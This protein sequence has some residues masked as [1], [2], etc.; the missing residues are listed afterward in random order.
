[1]ERSKG[2][3]KILALLVALMFVAL[4]TRLW[5]LQVL[6]SETYRKEA[7]NN[8]VRT[9]ETEPLRGEIFDRNG[10][11]VVS[12]RRAIE[13]RVIPQDLQESGK[14]EKVVLRL[15]DL[16]GISVEDL[17]ERM[18]NPEFYPFQP[19]PIVTYDG[20]R[21]RELGETVYAAIAER[22]R[23]YPGV[24][25]VKTT[26]R[27]YPQ[28]DLGAQLLGWLG[29]IDADELEELEKRG[30][31]PNDVVGKS[32][33]ERRW[34][35]FLRGKPGLEKFLVNA[36]GE[37]LRRLG[38]RD[39]VQ[40][41]NLYLTLDAGIQTI[42]EDALEKGIHEAR[43]H[44]DEDTGRYLNAPAGAVVV[45][46]P[47]T[48]GVIAMASW[49]SFDPEWF[50]AGPSER[51]QRYLF[52]S[53]QAPLLNRATQLSYSPGS[54]FKPFVALAAVEEGIAS[55]GGYY[56]CV[57]E[58]NAATDPDGRPFTNWTSDYLGYMTIAD[59][60]RVSCDT[61]YYQWGDRFWLEWRNEFAAA[62]NDPFQDRLSEWGFGSA[63]GIDLPGETDGLVPDAAWKEK[64]TQEH[65]E[66]FLPDE[67]AWLPGDSILLSIGG[68][69][70]LATPLQVAQAYGAIANGGKLCRPHLVERIVR[71]GV[72]VKRVGSPCKPVPY[73]EAEITYIR[74]A[75][76]LV[77]TG[78]T[79]ASVFRG[80]PL[81]EVP[82]A[83]KTGTAERAGFQ[84]TSWFAA[85]V[86][87]IDDPDYVVVAMVEE[88]G[89]GSET[90]APIVR[91]IVEGMYGITCQGSSDTTE[92]D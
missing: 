11:P 56:P 70:M 69:S 16:L 50:V 33:L 89:F 25:V 59:S 14:A 84:D 44:F 39:P 36:D 13:V 58:Y 21:E 32:G 45:L 46:D 63:T 72:V 1:M 66:L 85:L 7:R 12:N 86:G 81:S 92:A 60:L 57:G 88:G 26:V 53:E 73:T 5:F 8:G 34:E 27:E 83:G 48:G 35:R 71:E 62:N 42:A 43:L 19:K 82:V 90:S 54:T 24:E 91:N 55:L 52:E 30:Y 10:D 20:I 74:N 64:Y 78:G 2:R 3:L 17:R 79:A 87:P 47:D 68:G 80:C 31:G 38:G 9:A 29:R 4:T 49:P 15:S 23:S 61:V 67:T 75:L 65:P 18:E 51:Q 41:G 76:A 28:G 77:T 6:A 40:G 37:T 22:P